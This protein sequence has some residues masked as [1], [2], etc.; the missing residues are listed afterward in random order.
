MNIKTNF[1]RQGS[2]GLLILK[3]LPR[4]YYAEYDYK[5]GYLKVN[6]L[7]EVPKVWNNKTY[8][9]TH[10]R[11]LLYKNYDKTE[12]PIENFSDVQNSINEVITN[13]EIEIENFIESY[14]VGTRKGDRD[15][16]NNVDVTDKTT[17]EVIIQCKVNLCEFF[18]PWKM[19]KVDEYLTKP[20]SK[21]LEMKFSELYGLIHWNSHK[22]NFKEIFTSSI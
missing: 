19:E 13:I 8:Y 10:T 11:T 1:K 6:E 2:A 9:E 7:I 14:F 20:S 5:F 22:Q 18:K 21:L 15:I 4:N 3:G 16:L 12:V 17:K